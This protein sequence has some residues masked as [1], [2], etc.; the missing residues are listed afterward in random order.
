MEEIRKLFT[1]VGVTAGATLLLMILSYVLAKRKGRDTVGWF[2]APFFFGVNVLVVVTAVAFCFPDTIGWG[3]IGLS[4]AFVT[5]MTPV[6]L[7][8]LPA[9]ETEG[10]TRSC[11]SCGRIVA[12]KASSCKKCGSALEPVHADPTRKVK[13]PL[14]VCFLYESLIVLLAAVIFGFIG[15]FCV[16]DQPGIR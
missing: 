9:V 4:G 8:L 14:R 5:V 15:Y 7:A 16:P 2:L 1:Y 11:P 6:V 13:H 10:L 12:W 3:F